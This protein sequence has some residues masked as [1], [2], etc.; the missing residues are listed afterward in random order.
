[1][2]APVLD[3]LFVLV[4]GMKCESLWGW[5]AQV[6]S[7]SV[8]VR[9]GVV[10]VDARR[11][12]GYCLLFELKFLFEVEWQKHTHKFSPE[13]SVGLVL[14]NGDFTLFAT[15][16]SYQKLCLPVD[17][18][19]HCFSTCMGFMQLTLD[20]Q[21]VQHAYNFIAFPYQ[22]GAIFRFLECF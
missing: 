14:P 3:L 6:G 10:H 16:H 17:H 9:I 8:L 20:R 7:T 15:Q 21:L 5:R 18:F 1:L 2:L 12:S 13:K 11:N 19:C 4:N 22:I